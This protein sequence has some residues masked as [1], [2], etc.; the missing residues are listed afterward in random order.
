MAAFGI[1]DVLRDY[2]MTEFDLI[3]HEM[4]TDHGF[5]DFH[6][7]LFDEDLHNSNIEWVYSLTWFR[8]IPL[9]WLKR[10]WFPQELYWSE[11][12]NCAG[13]KVDDNPKCN[14]RPKELTVLTYTP[15]PCLDED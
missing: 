12:P 5:F 7:L 11:D 14:L 1:E 2:F 13:Y 3:L 15:K 8:A 6:K 4:E 9:K 10:N